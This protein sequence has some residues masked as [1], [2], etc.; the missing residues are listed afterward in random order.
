[1]VSHESLGQGVQEGCV[2][3]GA[4]WGMHDQA[5]P[6]VFTS[7]GLCSTSVLQQMQQ[8]GTFREEVYM[9]VCGGGGGAGQAA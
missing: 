7:M 1:M 3:M 5:S 9:C 4:C 6:A 2:C 8:K